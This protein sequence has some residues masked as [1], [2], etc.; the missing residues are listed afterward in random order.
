M[1]MKN[2]FG[3]LN[4]CTECMHILAWTIPC[5][6]LFYHEHLMP[7]QSKLLSFD[8]WIIQSYPFGWLVNPFMCCFWCCFLRM[9]LQDEAAFASQMHR[10]MMRCLCMDTVGSDKSFPSVFHHWDSSS[11]I[12][13]I[14]CGMFS[15]SSLAVRYPSMFSI[16]WLHGFKVFLC[17]LRFG[18]WRNIIK[19]TSPKINGVDK[20]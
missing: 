14:K 20:G 7:A 3:T 5:R 13:L 4:C 11:S 2:H 18:C 12:H 15:L 1:T 19:R 6:F 10:H 8:W 16:P 17:V 9:A